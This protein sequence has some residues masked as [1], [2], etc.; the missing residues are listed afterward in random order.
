M[1]INGFKDCTNA[2]AGVLYFVHCHRE[3]TGLTEEMQ[4]LA[5]NKTETKCAY[6]CFPPECGGGGGACREYDGD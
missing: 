4:V 5:L 1:L 2:I 6:R 3:N